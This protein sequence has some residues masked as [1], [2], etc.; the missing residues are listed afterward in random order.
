MAT[1]NATPQ[2]TLEVRR[3]FQA[4]RE[5]VF[6][7]WAEREQVEQWMFKGVHSHRITFHKNDIRPGGRYQVEAYDS[8]KKETYWG[9]GT[10]LEIKPPE[11]IS[12][13]WH[14]ALNAPEGN[15]LHPASPNTEVSVEFFERGKSTEVVLTHSVFHSQKERDEHN[16]GWVQCLDS[17]QE[18]LEKS[19]ATN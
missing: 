18:F 4:P 9:S 10:Y 7:A 15:A 6:A 17:L 19:S 3:T 12:Y 5:K 13:T 16:G 14:W 2:L 11:K 1:T 8:A